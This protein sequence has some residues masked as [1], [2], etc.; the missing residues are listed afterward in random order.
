MTAVSLGDLLPALVARL[1]AALQTAGPSG[2]VVP[3]YDFVPKR[4]DHLHVRVDGLF[5]LPGRRPGATHG[6]CR[7]A[8][9]VFDDIRSDR[10]TEAVHLVPELQALCVAALED[11]AP[12]PG[13]AP[14]THLSSALTEEEAETT[15]RPA[16]Q[17][18]GLSQFNTSLGEKRW[19]QQ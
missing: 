3:V 8:V 15:S 10:S 16:R 5:L 1:K 4:E 6:L 14:I 13:A 9:H 12:L 17:M 18:H 19:Q 11:W 7:F 2:R